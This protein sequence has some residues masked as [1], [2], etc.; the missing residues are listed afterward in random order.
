MGKIKI[1]L[2]WSIYGDTMK[3]VNFEGILSWENL[4][5]KVLLCKGRTSKVA[6]AKIEGIRKLE[7]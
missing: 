1:G 7:D 2:M 3:R 5:E 4:S 6:D